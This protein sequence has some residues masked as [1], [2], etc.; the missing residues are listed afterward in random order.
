MWAWRSARDA[1]ELDGALDGDM[2]VGG[3]GEVDAGEVMY[4]AL[5]SPSASKSE[6]IRRGTHT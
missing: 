4:A 6:T 5:L 2:V 1:L 3:E